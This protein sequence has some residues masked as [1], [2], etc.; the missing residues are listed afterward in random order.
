VGDLDSETGQVFISENQADQ[1]TIVDGSENVYVYN[2]GLNTFTKN[3]VPGFNAGYVEFLDTYTI[4]SNKNSGDWRLSAQNDSTTY[5]GTAVASMQTKAD[6]LQAVVTLERDVWVLGKIDGEKWNN[7]GR[8]E[9]PFERQN[10]ISMNYGCLNPATITNDFG[11]LV[12]LGTNKKAGTTIIMSTGGAA[13]ELSSQQD[14]LDF[15]LDGLQEPA[16]ASAFI[17][18]EDG[19]IIYQITW[20]ADNLSIAYDFNTKLWYELSDENQNHHIAKRAVLFNGKLFFISFN[21]SKLYQ[22]GTELTTYNGATIP[23]FRVCSHVRFEN[24]LPFIVNRVMLQMEQGQNQN[25]PGNVD[26]SISKDG[27]VTYYGAVCVVDGWARGG[28]WVCYGYV[29]LSMA[30]ETWPKINSI[31]QVPMSPDSEEWR[32]WGTIL[33]QELQHYFGGNGLKPPRLNSATIATLESSSDSIG[34]VVFNC[35]TNELMVNKTGTFVNIL[36]A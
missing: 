33:T 29:E 15:L 19:H 25:P 13:Q 18:Q 26:L 22:M 30:T 12:W 32:R 24:D 20:P 10:T 17:F 5:P 7:Q 23:R 3:P 9:F 2:Y 36:T 1:I 16:N 31:P 34:T 4:I 8:L 28:D 35:D 14:G 21:D 11:M 27:G 6:N